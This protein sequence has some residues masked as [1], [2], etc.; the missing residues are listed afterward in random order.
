ML[1]ATT[2]TT[3]QNI[4]PASGPNFHIGRDV[5]KSTTGGDVEPEFFAIGFHSRSKFGKHRA[6]FLHVG[7]VLIA[8]SF[9][10]QL[11]FS[12]DTEYIEWDEYQQV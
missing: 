4:K 8:E 2:T 1:T 10:H 12:F 5:R 11:L 9:H 7:A 6:N 3:M